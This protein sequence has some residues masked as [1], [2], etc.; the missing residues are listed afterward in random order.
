MHVFICVCLYVYVPG[1]VLDSISL[2]TSQ[3]SPGVGAYPPTTP[4]EPVADA[5]THRCIGGSGLGAQ[6]CTGSLPVRVSWAQG[7]LCSGGTFVFFSR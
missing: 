1:R 6:V 5:P 2:G 4:G 7:T 3:A